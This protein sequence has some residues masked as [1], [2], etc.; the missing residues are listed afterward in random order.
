MPFRCG[1]RWV[2]QWNDEEGRRRKKRG[3]ASKA[4]AVAHEA[5]WKAKSAAR[6]AESRQRTRLRAAESVSAVRERNLTVNGGNCRLEAS[7]IGWLATLLS[8]KWGCSPVRDGAHTDFAVQRLAEA[9]SS[10]SSLWYGIQVKATAKRCPKG[11]AKFQVMV[12]Y[13]D[14]IVLCVLLDERRVWAFHGR[15]LGTRAFSIGRRSP[16]Y[17]RNECRPEDLA[18]RLCTMLSEGEYER[19]PLAA[20]DVQTLGNFQYLEHVAHRAWTRLDT[21]PAIVPKRIGDLENSVVDYVQRD[22]VRVQEK[23]CSEYQERPGFAVHLCKK[24]GRV[25]GRRVKAP[26]ESDDVDLFR[27]LLMARRGADG[28]WIFRRSVKNDTPVSDA[29]R[30]LDALTLV[31]YWEIPAAE[32]DRHGYLTRRSPEGAVQSYGKT[33]LYAYPSAAFCERF[34]WREPRHSNANSWTRAFFRAV[35]VESS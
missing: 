2:A 30:E 20:L 3:F 17:E 31:G 29:R 25:R 14:A 23:T 12:D 22:G 34:A 11:F 1:N 15:E 9:S 5:P 8:E 21:S 33:M 28:R 18:G 13:S 16:T 32:L 4:L 10:S 7:A 19:R 24:G 26:Y 27:V 6:A 35:D